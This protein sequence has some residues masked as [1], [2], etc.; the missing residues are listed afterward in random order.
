MYTTHIYADTHNVD[1]YIVFTTAEMY[2]YNTYIY[3]RM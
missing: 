3:V 2:T 1:K